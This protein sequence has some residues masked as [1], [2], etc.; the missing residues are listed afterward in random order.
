MRSPRFP[1][2]SS[3]LADENQVGKNLTT[4]GTEGT[5]EIICYSSVPSVVKY[6]FIR[7]IRFGSGF[8]RTVYEHCAS[9]MLAPRTP[10]TTLKS[11]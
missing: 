9:W 1:C 7:G 5:E 4:E 10:S 3:V 2:F 11:S 8:F 6:F